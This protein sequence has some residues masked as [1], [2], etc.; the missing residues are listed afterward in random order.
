[1]PPVPPVCPLTLGAL[2]SDQAVQEGFDAGDAGQ[3]DGVQRG[4]PRLLALP[5][6]QPQVAD[7]LQ[8]LPRVG[9][10]SCCRTPHGCS[11]EPHGLGNWGGKWKSGAAQGVMGP[12]CCPRLVPALCL[13]RGGMAP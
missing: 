7:A 3:Q 4:H 13:M 2:H 6:L 5:R 9:K 12:N 10:G 1:M 11:P 8:R